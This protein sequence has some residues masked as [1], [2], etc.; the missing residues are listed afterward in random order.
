VPDDTR[1]PEREASTLA[2]P[3]TD[4]NARRRRWWPAI[5]A[6]VCGAAL[7]AA[8]PVL[9]DA[10]GPR[11]ASGS[12]RPSILVVVTDDQRADLVWPMSTLLERVG[13]RGVLF[14]NGFVP[15]A[16]CCPARASIL[17][18]NHSHRTGVWGNTLRFG[19]SAFDE[20]STLATWLQDAGYRTGLFGKY[21]NHWYEPDP[22]HV[23][24]GWDEWFAF[25]E[26][27]CAYDGFRASVNG[28]PT[29]FGSDVY[30]TTETARRAAAFIRADPRTPT[31]LL[32]TPTAPHIPA[33]PAPEHA[34]AFANLAPFRPP[35][36]LEGDVGDKPPW[37]RT[38]R[39]WRAARREAMDARRRRMLET[40]LSVD[41]GLGILLD[42]LEES[43]RLSNTLI[44]FT[45]DN[46]YLLGEHRGWGK[47]FAW[48]AGHRVPFVV[49]YDRLVRSP[50]TSVAPVL[51][52]DIAPT[53]ADAA[54]IEAPPMEGKS[55]LPI[56][57]GDRARVRTT[58]L[59]EHGRAGLSPPYCGARSR[60]SL[61]VRYATGDEEFYDY[62]NDPWELSNAIADPVHAA[63]I[64]QL[65][66]FARQR[67]DPPP[68]GLS[69]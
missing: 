66:R 34:G 20:S 51:T 67:C 59:I 55:L 30:S 22:H 2:T 13:E 38:F 61:F 57:R 37:L 3:S 42:A 31:F 21:L 18:G 28:T 45:S 10:P 29:A 41:D 25:Q 11:G 62:R 26:N 53:I 60:Y 15:H 23:P 48:D 56:L 17:T 36:Y 68:P 39:I 7:L 5:V 24:P 65:R 32:W 40:L 35:S 33:T 58:F 64:E 4:G 50:A 69:W 6:L 19:Y 52:I 43:G 27:C 63:R 46:G 44:M 47:P 49:R 12:E 8:S 14:E 16:A 9:I 54:G 1:P